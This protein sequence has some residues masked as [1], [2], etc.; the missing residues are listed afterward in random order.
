MTTTD[1]TVLEVRNLSTVF[2]SDGVELRAV[3]DVS[4]EVRRGETLGIVG[5]SGSGKSVTCMSLVQLVGTGPGQRVEGT[6]MFDGEDTLGM[7]GKRL[8]QLRGGE[9]SV[10]F[11]EPMT[12]LNPLFTIGDQLVEAL[13]LHARVSKAEAQRQ[14]IEY[15]AKVGI[16][17]PEQVMSRYP[18]TLSGGMRQRVVIAM[19]LIPGPRLVIADEPTTALD[20]T[21][22]AQIL[23]L[24]NDLKR[25][26]GA[27]VVFISHDLGAV[28]EMADRVLVMYGGRIVEEATR[29]ELF[30]RPRHPYTRA[31]IASHPGAAGHE[32]RLVTIPGTVPPLSQMPSGCPFNNRCEFATDRCR[33]E[34]PA[35]VAVG[36]DHRAFCW[37]LDEVPDAA[38]V[39][40]DPSRRGVPAAIAGAGFEPE[41]TLEEPPTDLEIEKASAELGMLDS[42]H[43]T[44]RPQA[45]QESSALMRVDGGAPTAV[46]TE[47]FPGATL[48]AA[49]GAEHLVVADGL[50]KHF[51]VRGGVLRRSSSAV[52]AVDDVSFGIRRGTVMGLVGE[53]GSGKSTVGRLAMGFSSPDAGSIAFDGEPVARLSQ[54]EAFALTAR[55]QMVFQDPSSSMNPRM[56]VRDII[57]EG[58]VAHRLAP[59]GSE[60]R[61]RVDELLITCGL[62][63]DAAAKYPHQFSGGQR[64]R[65]AI[66]R[67]LATDPAFLVCDEAVSALDVSVQAQIV[68]LLTDLRDERDLTY[69]FIS[70]DLNVVRYISDEVMVM[71][72][73]EIIER[74]TTEQIF[75]DPR[76]PYTRALLSAVPTFTAEEN[77][78]RESIVLKGDIPSPID[79]APGCRFAGRCPFATAVCRAETPKAVE[80]EE[81][82]VVSCVLAY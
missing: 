17:S 16:P 37:N 36:D 42:L 2:R 75:S 26:T 50:V 11:Q 33:E 67:A 78:V 9:I 18:F 81:G 13:R 23:D 70:H 65:V 27:S 29:E 38:V 32:E 10:I 60:L 74:G 62:S 22:Q 71:Y 64:Q 82:H 28:N 5:E 57:G 53:S 76:H 44:M 49:S 47:R 48:V 30:S 20:V 12:A 19:A 14:A 68:N 31:L 25:D 7:K 59:S 52:H 72:L 40:Y 15:L 3:N 77:S 69:L 21:I 61:D 46:V 34:F 58:L 79:P 6:A 51:P 4:F 8:R 45:H 1:E 66:A 24:L 43:S 35:P 56:R 41:D 54:N 73:G 55:R 63:P 39:D 80:V